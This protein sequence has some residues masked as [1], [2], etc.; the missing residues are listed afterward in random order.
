MYPVYDSQ[1]TVKSTSPYLKEDL[2]YYIRDTK[3]YVLGPPS[4]N[5][6]L[7]GYGRGKT[8]PLM[9]LIIHDI[10]GYTSMYSGGSR[11]SRLRMAR[12]TQGAPPAAMPIR[13][14]GPSMAWLTRGAPGRTPQPELQRTWV[15][16]SLPNF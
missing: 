2:V 8:W 16:P 9:K 4:I 15:T 14:K 3:V 13:W 6:K 1:L 11:L 7:S 5:I 12:R 10:Y